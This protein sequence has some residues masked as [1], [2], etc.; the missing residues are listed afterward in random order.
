[1]TLPSQ[2]ANGSWVKSE[3]ARAQESR[4]GSEG[5]HLAAK[6][7]AYLTYLPYTFS[8]KVRIEAERMNYKERRIREKQEV[9]QSILDA[10][11]KIARKEGWHA[12]TIRR[13]ADEIEYTPPIVYEHFESKETLFRE[14]IYSGFRILHT[15][16]EKAKERER[17]PKKL[18]LNLSLINW[19]FAFAQTDL[20]QLMFSL[21]RPTPSE[22]MMHYFGLVESMFLEFAKSDKELS[23][24][25]LL[26]WASLTHG[27]IS[28]LMQLP[29]P[30]HMTKKGTRELYLKMIQR[31]ISSI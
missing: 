25:L 13:I 12:V 28:F 19:D 18:L 21:E 24:D 7:L 15:D 8:N 17:D 1:M 26:N 10:S 30:P 29:P 6:S 20:F 2:L 5:Y 23:E 3:T 31:F 16:F 4:L 22:E 9:R 11:R 14:L 27:A